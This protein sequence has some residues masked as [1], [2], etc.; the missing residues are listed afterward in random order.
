M[1][2]TEKAVRLLEQGRERIP[3]SKIVL[4][5][6]GFAYLKAGKRKEA[7]ETCQSVLRLDP[8]FFDVL[9][10]AGTIMWME[11]RWAEALDYFDDALVI[12]PENKILQQRHAF[13]LRAMGKSP[14]PLNKYQR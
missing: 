5:G 9:F 8:Q 1:G 2:K 4:T 6:L 11:K 14:N 7:L 10:L 12:E 3:D 13:C